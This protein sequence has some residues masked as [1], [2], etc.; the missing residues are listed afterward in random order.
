MDSYFRQSI[1]GNAY[2][3]RTVNF[4][5][6][7]VDTVETDADNSYFIATRDNNGGSFKFSTRY[8]Y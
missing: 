6:D 4:W 7:V 3:G 2:E 8:C 5:D 1:N